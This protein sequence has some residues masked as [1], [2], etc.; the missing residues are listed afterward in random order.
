M[1]HSTINWSKIA[2]GAQDDKRCIREGETET[3]PWEHYSHRNNDESG[4]YPP[5]E[6]EDEGLVD[7]Q[8]ADAVKTEAKMPTNAHLIDAIK[9]FQQPNSLEEE[10]LLSMTLDCEPRNEGLVDPQPLNHVIT[11]ATIPHDSPIIDAVRAFQQPKSMEED[12]LLSLVS[13]VPR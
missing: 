3:L 9:V 11:Q 4:E 13:T 2:L 7:S 1:S 8:P 12:E 10:E 5:P 6:P